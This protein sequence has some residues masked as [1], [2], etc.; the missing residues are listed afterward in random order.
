MRTIL[1]FKTHL[2]LQKILYINTHQRIYKRS[3]EILFGLFKFTAAETWIWYNN[4]TL[5]SWISESFRE[6]KLVCFFFFKAYHSHLETNYVYPLRKW[7]KIFIVLLKNLEDLGVLKDENSS[8]THKKKSPKTRG[9]KEKNGICASC[10]FW[11]ITHR[12]YRTTRNR[13]MWLTNIPGFTWLSHWPQ[14]VPGDC[15]LLIQEPMANWPVQFSFQDGFHT[16]LPGYPRD[17]SLLTSLHK[18]G[19]QPD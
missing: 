11:K 15:L 9:W 7:L 18:L 4:L 5:K 17:R 13:Q 3:T 12:R 2:G 6:G 19:E 8:H 14:Q 1:Y 16:L 10:F